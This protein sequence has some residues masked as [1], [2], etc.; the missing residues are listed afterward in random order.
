MD[1]VI[2]YFILLFLLNAAFKC[3]QDILNVKACKLIQTVV[4]H[5]T[6]P[7]TVHA[8]MEP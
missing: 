8:S 2:L 7:V 6:V 4:H 5:E 1:V 3:C